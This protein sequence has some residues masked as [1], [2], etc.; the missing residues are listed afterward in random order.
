MDRNV[1]RLSTTGQL[2]EILTAQ[3]DFTSYVCVGP[4]LVN[5]SGVRFRIE[6][7]FGQLIQNHFPL[8]D[9]KLIVLNGHVLFDPEGRVKA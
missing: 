4:V 6:N 1:N 7:P 9:L 2:L 8:K 3:E 5:E